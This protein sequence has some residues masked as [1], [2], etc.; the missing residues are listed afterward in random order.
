L[1]FGVLDPLA[2]CAPGSGRIFL[3]GQDTAPT[4][5]LIRV[6]YRDPG[7][8]SVFNGVF[9]DV[10][11]NDRPS[12]AAGPRYGNLGQT[13][14][15]IT[16]SRRPTGVGPCTGLNIG[17]IQFA[18]SDDLLGPSGSPVR[19]RPATLTTPCDYEGWAA[20]SVIGNDGSITVVSRDGIVPATGAGMYNDRRPY[21]MRSNDGGATW[22]PTAYPPILLDG[23]SSIEVGRV[24]GTNL[25]VGDWAYGIDR[26]SSSP[27]IAI[28]RRSSQ[29]TCY[30]AFGTSEQPSATARELVAY[31]CA[32]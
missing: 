10:P 27:C 28:D 21:I 16:S 14:F 26:R 18:P 8:S 23:Q 1:P 7:Q 3:G 25:D 19:L 17:P 5:D 24:G 31:L 22:G 9:G 30:V 29:A 11:V 32:A 13:R 20:Q 4:P 2:V 15:S 12:I 6:T